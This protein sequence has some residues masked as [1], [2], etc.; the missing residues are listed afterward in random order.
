MQ[1]CTNCIACIIM[2]TTLWPGQGY[3]VCMLR[4]NSAHQINNLYL[5]AH[6][7]V[8]IK[9]DESG[10]PFIQM[11]AYFVFPIAHLAALEG[12]ASVFQVTTCMYAPCTYLD[13][14]QFIYG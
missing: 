3:V 9:N 13:K 10:T 6:V 5:T 4:K 11:I 14:L 8:D 12:I 7:H 2:Y 1:T